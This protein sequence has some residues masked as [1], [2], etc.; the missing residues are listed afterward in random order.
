MTWFSYLR[1]LFLY[2]DWANR[3]VLR[4]LSAAAHPTQRSRK[5]LAHVVGTEWVWRSRILRQP[6]Q[7]AVWPDWD[8]AEAGRQI[9]RLR[10]A[11]DDDFRMLEEKGLDRAVSYVNTAGQQFSSTVGDI[12]MHVVMHS[13]YHRGQIA[14]DMRAAGDEPVYTDF[15]HAL[16]QGK[17]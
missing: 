17:L 8:V 6:Q 5:L 16:R 14:A 11:W 10:T 9:A 7:V 15:I 3:E 2:D 4:G 1:R 13:A 12:L